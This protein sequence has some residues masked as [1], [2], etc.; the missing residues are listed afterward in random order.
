MASHPERPVPSLLTLISPWDTRRCSKLL[1]SIDALGL[2]VGLWS[3][4]HAGPHAAL[5]HLD[6]V[7]IDEPQSLAL[8]YA[9]VSIVFVGGTLFPVR[10]LP[11]PVHVVAVVDDAATQARRHH[12]LADVAVCGCTIVTGPTLAQYE[13][14]NAHT[15]PALHPPLG[16]AG[17]AQLGCTGRGGGIARGAALHRWVAMCLKIP[18]STVHDHRDGVRGRA[19]RRVARCPSRPAGRPA[20]GGHHNTLWQHRTSAIA[21]AAEGLRVHAAASQGVWVWVWAAGVTA[22][23]A[24]RP[25]PRRRTRSI[26]TVRAW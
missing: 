7:L 22:N 14:R 23:P 1:R 26:I 18:R 4:S 19:G 8:L 16:H 25:R 15:D 13:V 20:G 5:Q 9:S 17:R 21:A 12:S 24:R 11:H 3:Q 10:G 6:V 2:R